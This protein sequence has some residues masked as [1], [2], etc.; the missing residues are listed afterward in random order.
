[1]TQSLETNPHTYCQLIFD[2]GGKNIQWEKTVSS[3][4]VLGK[5]DS[6]M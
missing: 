5:Q 1:M 6:Y 2:E 3:P 4:V